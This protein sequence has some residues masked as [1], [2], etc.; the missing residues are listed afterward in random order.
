LLNLLQSS[1]CCVNKQI[2]YTDFITFF[3]YK[4]E[5]LQEKFPQKHHYDVFSKSKWNL[6]FHLTLLILLIL[7]ILYLNKPNE[8]VD[9]PYS[10]FCTS[11]PELICISPA[12]VYNIPVPPAASHSFIFFFKSSMRTYSFPWQKF[13]FSA[14]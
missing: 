8:P 14:R 4:K 12:L 13:I 2:W 10:S 7:L 6:V 3:K 11:Q 5:D 9:L 1:V